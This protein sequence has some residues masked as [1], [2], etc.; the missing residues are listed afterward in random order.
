MPLGILE[1]LRAHHTG[2]EDASRETHFATV[3][4]A[5]PQ[6]AGLV[7]ESKEGGEPTDLRAVSGSG[8]RDGQELR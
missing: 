4:G 7:G 5:A 8:G 3:G 1:F 2:Q 6:I